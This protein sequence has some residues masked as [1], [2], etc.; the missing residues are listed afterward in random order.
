MIVTTEICDLER[1][2]N[3][4]ILALEP[5]YFQITSFNC[6][7]DQFRDISS[8]IAI[9]NQSLTGKEQDQYFITSEQKQLQKV[10]TSTTLRFKVPKQH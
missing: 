10:H 6:L 5:W 1:N 9:F 2:I 8:K 4:K 7:H 3:P